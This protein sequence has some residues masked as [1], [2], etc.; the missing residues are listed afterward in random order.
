MDWENRKLRGPSMSRPNLALPDPEMLV[1]YGDQ[2]RRWG[3]LF[4]PTPPDSLRRQMLFPASVASISPIL[5]T[6]AGHYVVRKLRSMTQAEVNLRTSNIPRRVR[7]PA[8]HQ[9][10]YLGR[11]QKPQVFELFKI[12][13]NI[14][15]N[16]RHVGRKDACSLVEASLGFHGRVSSNWLDNKMGN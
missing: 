14:F 9:A 13:N 4:A 15:W 7:F 16:N 2:L 3:P 12:G 8:I 11:L 6:R 10:V 1:R 5:D